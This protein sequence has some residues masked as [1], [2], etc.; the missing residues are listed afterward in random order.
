MADLTIYKCPSCNGKLEFNPGQQEMVCP[1]CD[2]AIDV[3]ALQAM[4]AA[5]NQNASSGN[6]FE[7]QT[8]DEWEPGEAEGMRVY[9]CQTCGGEVIADETTAASTC[10]YCD[11]PVVMQGQLA[12][13]LKPEAVIPFKLDKE[14]AKKSLM[15]HMSGKFLLPKV[16]KEE[17]HIDEIKGVYVP[18]WLY[19]A[20]TDSTMIY[21]GCK[22]RR[23]SDDDY[24]Y[25]EHKYYACVRSGTMSFENVPVDGSTKMDDTMME[26]LEPFDEKEMQAFSMAYLSGYL[27]D[28]YDVTAEDNMPHAEE[29]MRG[30]V[31]IEMEKT[32][33]EYDSFER[34]SES[35]QFSEG[36]VRYVLY[37]VWLLN[38]SWNG[39]TFHFG[40]NGQSGKFVG[41]LPMDKLKGALTF[42]ITT[43]L[44]AVISLLIGNAVSD[45]GLTGTVIIICAVISLIIGG[46]VF[47]GFA[48]ALKSVIP[49]HEATDYIKD[50]LKL[51]VRT[52]SYL[53]KKVDRTA[54]AKSND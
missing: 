43:I 45:K 39:K 13:D 54:R 23:W 28:K 21:K 29:R 3:A 33:K 12:G 15:Q 41:N 44:A 20:D 4:D 27:A 53:Y 52:D 14:A 7:A 26:S 32:L 2:S 49:K 10:P 17:N 50:N 36:Q 34:Q 37:P 35:V 51:S 48:S 5:L 22:T 19:A 8:G 11:N 25:V 40:M 47:A 16:F 31:R 46:C 42:I 6:S 24:D 18:V 1:F 38:T 30:S 9:R